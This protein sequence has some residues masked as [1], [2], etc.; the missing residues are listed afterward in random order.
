MSGSQPELSVVCK[1]CGSE[2]SPYVTECPYCG[3][4]VRKRAPKLQRLGEP[5]KPPRAKRPRMPRIG[6]PRMPAV[7]L[8]RDR[9]YAT[10]AALVIP[11]LLILIERATTLTVVDLGAIATSGDVEWWRYLAAPFAYTQVGYFFV[12]G[13]AIAIFGR[14]LERRLGTVA[15]A[16]LLVACGALG[17]VVAHG[18]ES[19]G[20]ETA[21]IGAAGGNGIALGA[22][23]AWLM[24]HL[25]EQRQMAASQSSY[26]AD[27]ERDPIG[28]AVVAVV[29]LALPLVTD[30]ANVWA[31]LGGAVA[32][33]AAGVISVALGRFEG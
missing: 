6:R 33:G 12:I 21:V 30:W 32:G 3:T 31:G 13:I 16:V 18:L 23:A 11:A 7:R 20:S 15:T 10:L 1:N 28:L 25:R 24:I 17:M 9:P 27:S 29:L 22:L 2:V 26:P 14:G 19:I 5:V 4:R 8:E